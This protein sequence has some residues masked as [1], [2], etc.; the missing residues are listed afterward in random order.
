MNTATIP[1]IDVACLWEDGPQSTRRVA[2][3]IREAAM[4]V[5]FFYVYHHGIAP[6]V[7][8]HA[9]DASRRFFSFPT[10]TKAEIAVNALN[11]GFMEIGGATMRNADTHDVKEVFFFGPE[12]PPDDPDVLA[13]KPLMGANQWPDFMPELR[14]AVHAY[15]SAAMDVG[16]RLLGAIAV[17]LGLPQ[18]FFASRYRKPLGRG[19]LIYYPPQ[20]VSRSFQY[21][22]APHTDFG[23][24]TVLLQDDSGGLS[25]RTPA[26]EWVDAPPIAG[27]LVVNIGDLLQRWSNERLQSTV[28]RVVNHAAAPRHSIAIFCDPDSDAVIDPR[29]MLRVR[30]DTVRYEPVTAGEYIVSRNHD[31]FAHYA[32]S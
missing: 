25:I 21:G 13:G 14:D 1:I 2:S 24:I 16:Q 6:T 12:L 30:D 10:G 3:E 7:S 28:H 27:T 4:R 11:R 18:T 31:A 32:R 19:Q 15:Y 20:D 26:G 29:D 22:V 8:A 17:A 23:C 9:L 5:G